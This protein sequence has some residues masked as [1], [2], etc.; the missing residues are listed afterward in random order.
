M[1]HLK[2]LLLCLLFAVILSGCS[3][4]DPLIEDLYTD[5]SYIRIDSSDDGGYWR[6]IDR[7]AIN[8]H[9]NGGVQTVP[10]LVTLG[11]W[12][13]NNIADVMYFTVRTGDDW[14]G[15]SD[16]WVDIYFEV[17]E[18]NTLG[19]VTDT[20]DFQLECWH[21]LVGEQICTVVSLDSTTVV[22]QADHNDLF[23]VSIGIVDMREDEL[24][25]FRLNLNTIDSEVDNVIV[26]YIEYRYQSFL[27]EREVN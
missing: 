4:S 19:L 16:G 14:D 3:A 7:D 15:N 1:K 5:A 12:W 22:G 17:N 20:V 26:N 2:W 23:M 25:S 10:N 13:L 27:P 8:I 9:C 6:V 11:G 18:D 21:K 24:I